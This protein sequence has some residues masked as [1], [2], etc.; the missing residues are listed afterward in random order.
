M[1]EE[2]HEKANV[3]SLTSNVVN[4]CGNPKQNSIGM[5]AKNS[6]SEMQEIGVFMR[7]LGGAV[8]S[9][10][11]IRATRLENMDTYHI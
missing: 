11:M 7:Q 5:E 8:V 3:N 4:K 10:S 2:K 9:V 1:I 6:I